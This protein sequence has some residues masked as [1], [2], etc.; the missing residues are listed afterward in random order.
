MKQIEERIKKSKLYAGNILDY[1]RLSVK[2]QNFLNLS[3]QEEEEELVMTYELEEEKPLTELTKE[4]ELTKLAVLYEVNRLETL[5]TT[6]QFTLDPNNLYYDVNNQIKVK[7]RD[8]QKSREPNNEF[9][10]Q[11]K[12]I[13][14][15]SLQ[16]KYSYEDYIQGGKSLLTKHFLL[17]RIFPLKTVGEVAVL[18]KEERERVQQH[19]EKTKI[20]IKKT[21]YH[22]LRMATVILLLCV[23]LF[24]GYS[25]YEFFYINPFQAAVIS[26]DTAFVKKN[27]TGVIDAL[28]DYEVNRLSKIQKYELAF[29]YIK[30]EALDDESKKV[31]LS[32]V[33]IKSQ[34]E[35]MEYWIFLGRNQVDNAINIAAKESDDALL[36]IAYNKKVY[37]IK[38]DVALSVE[39]KNT[40][41]QQVKEQLNTI[42]KKYEK[43]DKQELS[44]SSSINDETL[45]EEV[46]PGTSEEVAPIGNETFQNESIGD[47]VENM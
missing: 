13:V 37:V 38:D 44:P 19:N 31:L 16:S 24:G 36:V 15:C 30:E 43:E 4:K 27:Y 12:A 1:K 25:A 39:E 34:E 28:H 29:A 14:G 9:L 47:S 6:Y 10:N 33:T 45:V 20:E 23:C 7:L 46:T 42:E 3:I 26:A 40:Q 41:I 8:I 32:K 17:N 18:L 2:Q 21:S 11:Y 35:L 5:F 22:S